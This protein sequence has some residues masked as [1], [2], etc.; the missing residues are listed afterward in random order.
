MEFADRQVTL[1][2]EV[3]LGAVLLVFRSEL[4]RRWRSWLILVVLIAVVGG[5]VLAAVAAGRRTASAFPRFVTAHGYDVYIFNDQPVPG[6]AHLPAVASVTSDVI[7]GYGQPTCACNHSINPSNFYINELTPTGLN[8]VV[9]LVAGNMPDPSSPDDVLASF[10]LQQDYGIHVGSSLQVPFYATSQKAALNSNGNVAPTGPT[11]TLHVVGIVAAEV[12]FPSGQAP[13]YDLFT[14]PAFARSVNH[15]TLEAS[16]YFV[17][18]HHG[19]NDLP[20]FAAALDPLHVTYV[21]NQ[22]TSAQA[23][24]ESIHPQ[25]VGW[26]ILAALTALAG[27]AVIGQGLGRQSIVESEEYPKLV[28][29]GL[30]RRSLIVLGMARNL[31]LALVGAAGAVVVAF[32]LSPLA[33]VGEARLAEPSPGF[34]FDSLILL[35]GALAIVVVVGVLG[36][37]PAIRASRVR[38]EGLQTGQFHASSIVARLSATALLRARSSASATLWSEAGVRLQSRWEPHSSAPSLRSLPSVRLRSSAPACRT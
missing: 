21:S 33:P 35:L 34:A 22:D 8:R 36:L 19:T 3:M 26:W 17:R 37:W 29:L 14:T 28:A 6:L 12:E 4:R 18:L 24:A 5:L 25:A 11:V 1:G 32:A 30:P 2:G 38:A 16:V 7:P 20:R 9:K 13:E 27:L 10:T 23:V 31:V 15:R